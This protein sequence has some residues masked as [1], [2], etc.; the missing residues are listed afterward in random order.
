MAVIDGQQSNQV[1]AHER[2]KPKAQDLLGK[3]T[4]GYTKET[5]GDLVLPVRTDSRMPE[6]DPKDSWMVA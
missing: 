6:L 1:R 2:S 4:G 5:G 3:A